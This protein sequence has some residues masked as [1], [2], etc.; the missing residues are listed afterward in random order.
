MRPPF[1]RDGLICVRYCE[2]FAC[3]LA[4]HKMT[5]HVPTPLTFE[6][7]LKEEH[8][9]RRQRFADAVKRARL[10]ENNGQDVDAIPEWKGAEIHF[11]SHMRAYQLHLANQMVRPEVLYLKKRAVDLDVPYHDLV[12]RS[13]LKK[14]VETRRLL[15]WE[16]REVFGLSFLEIGR[17]FGWRDSSTAMSAVKTVEARMRR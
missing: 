13:A 7:K 5:I 4:V 17:A 12:G 3:L 15:M 2:A 10:R 14:V 11:D 9:A 1:H 8:K 6:A 16:L